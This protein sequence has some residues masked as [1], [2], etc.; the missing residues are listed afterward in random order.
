MNEQQSI[1]SETNQIL[2]DTWLPYLMD[3]NL[4]FAYISA[5]ALVHFVKKSPFVTKLRRKSEKE[6]RTIQSSFFVG[7]VTTL[8]FKFTDPL[9]I[10]IQM[11]FL[12]GATNSLIYRS[13]IPIIGF[14]IPGLRKKLSI[15]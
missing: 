1:I 2:I 6:W 5:W 15:D 12:V 10:M 8:V 13:I 4:I 14:I 3:T 7:F 9:L 11:A